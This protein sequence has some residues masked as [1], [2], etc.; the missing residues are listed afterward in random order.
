MSLQAGYG[1]NGE[2]SKDTFNESKKITLG[3]FYLIFFIQFYF[4]FF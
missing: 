2:L 3:Y 4:I 1:S